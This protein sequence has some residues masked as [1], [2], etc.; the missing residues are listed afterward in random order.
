[1]KFIEADYPLLK[2]YL[3]DPELKLS[4]WAGLEFHFNIGHAMALMED[5]VFINHGLSFL[6]EQINSQAC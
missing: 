3:N 1:V 6:G 5:F 2:H 4:F